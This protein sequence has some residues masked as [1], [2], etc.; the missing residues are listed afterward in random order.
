M[1]WDEWDIADHHVKS[2]KEDLTD[3]IC[4]SPECEAQLSEWD[5][6]HRKKRCPYHWRVEILPKEYPKVFGEKRKSSL[7]DEVGF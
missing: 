4:V 2:M 7:K 6:S 3:Q 5:V 1:A